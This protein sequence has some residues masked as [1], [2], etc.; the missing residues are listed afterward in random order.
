MKFLNLLKNKYLI[1][2]VALIAWLLFFDKND[3]Y[4]QLDLVKRCNKLK[5][6][7]EYYLEEIANNQREI[8]ELKHNAKSLETF[9]REK[10]FMKKDNEDVFVIIKKK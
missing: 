4:S 10:Y 6:E 1:V 9:A 5:A 3:V 8:D 2:I 7:K